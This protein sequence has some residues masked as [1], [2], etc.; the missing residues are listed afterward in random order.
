MLFECR[1]F[2]FVEATEA[3]GVPS[4]LLAFFVVQLGFKSQINESFENRF[5]IV[6]RFLRYLFSQQ[7]LKKHAWDRVSILIRLEWTYL[8][9]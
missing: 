2:G 4:E 1:R 9:N 8:L 5:E 7:A 3:I 6:H